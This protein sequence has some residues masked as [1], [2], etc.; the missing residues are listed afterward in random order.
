[1]QRPDLNRLT[2]LNNCPR[3]TEPKQLPARKTDLNNC[4]RETEPKRL[5]TRKRIKFGARKSFMS[6][7]KKECN[8]YS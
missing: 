5:P 7:R 1:M 3:E 4:P 6:A 8:V 2:D